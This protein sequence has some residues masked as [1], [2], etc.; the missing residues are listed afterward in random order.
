MDDRLRQLSDK[1]D[2]VLRRSQSRREQLF[3]QRGLPVAL[4]KLEQHGLPVAHLRHE[5][6]LANIH[7]SSPYVNLGGRKLKLKCFVTLGILNWIL[8]KKAELA[9][10]AR[11]QRP[12]NVRDR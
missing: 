2:T 3:E 5:S 1:A 11:R 6:K 9:R 8:R 10:N 4:L 7:Y 12:R